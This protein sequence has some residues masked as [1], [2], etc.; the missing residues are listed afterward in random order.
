MAVDHPVAVFRL[1]QHEVALGPRAVEGEL[2]LG[3]GPLLHLV[4]APVPNRHAATSVLS[5]G[6]FPLEGGVLKGMVLGVHGQA[7]LVGGLGE[8]LGDGP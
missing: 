3:V 6:D 2:D 1:E 5:L 8:A 4:V 7:V